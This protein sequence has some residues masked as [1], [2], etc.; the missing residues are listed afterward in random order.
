MLKVLD[1]PDGAEV[2]LAGLS[3]RLYVLKDDELTLGP[4][5]KRVG[6]VAS[7]ALISNTANYHDSGMIDHRLSEVLKSCMD[8]AEFPEET[9]NVF[10]AFFDRLRARYGY[11]GR[12]KEAVTVLAEKA[13][14]RFLDG[15]FLDP[16]IEDYHRVGVFKERHDETNLLSNVDVKVLLDWCQQGDF[17][18][19]LVMISRAIYPFEKEPE[20]EGIVL[21]EQAKAIIDAIQDPSMVLANF[22]SSVWLSEGWGSLAS[23]IA[24]RRQA[25]EI[26]LKRDRSDI[27]SAAAIQIERIKKWEEQERRSERAEDKLREQRF[28]SS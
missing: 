19:R 13:T 23:S 26:L 24:K 27:R 22:A 3:M 7:A 18:E 6:L 17:Q 16:A 10:G 12:I 21:S 15:I 2:V 14:F 5:L 28:E 25:F 20:G 9:S 8:E 4:D 1:R 11:L